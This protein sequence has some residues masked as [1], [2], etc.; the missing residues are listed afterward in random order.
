MES[1]DGF[2]S[3]VCR[4]WLQ[5]TL[6]TPVRDAAGQENVW[7][8]HQLVFLTIHM[9]DDRGRNFLSSVRGILGVW[10]LRLSARLRQRRAT[11]V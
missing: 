7:I 6:A 3:S 1:A 9:T 11:D 8:E 5:Q 4:D 2:W 10:S